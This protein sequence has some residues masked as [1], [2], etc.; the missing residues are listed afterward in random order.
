MLKGEYHTTQTEVESQ[1]SKTEVEKKDMIEK[2]GVNVQLS[3]AAGSTLTC[4]GIG[5]SSSV[6]R[7]N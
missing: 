4:A 7:E 6:N 5:S 3:R 2:G 1:K